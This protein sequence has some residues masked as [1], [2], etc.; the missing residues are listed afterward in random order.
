MLAEE[1]PERI[2]G[3]K[4]C[5]S[6]K[7]DQDMAARNFEMI[8]PHR[9]NRRSE[10]VTQDGRALRRCNY[11]WRVERTISWIQSFRR[12]CTWWEK[13]TKLF[14]GYL[15]VSWVLLLLKQVVG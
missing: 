2:T 9:S 6:D 10:N 7:L 12:L 8:A 14:Q 15:Y 11:R 5:D 13:S 1:T 3:G 4:A